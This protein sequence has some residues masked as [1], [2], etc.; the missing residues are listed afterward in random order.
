MRRVK[1]RIMYVG[2][3]KNS[4]LDLDSS[5]RGHLAHLK[6]FGYV[7]LTDIFS[8]AVLEQIRASY[9]I[10][11]EEKLNFETPCLAQNKID[12]GKHKILLDNYLR[13]TPQQ[14]LEQGIA[15]TK[16]EVSSY[17]QVLTE[18]R[19]STLKTYIPNN[20]VFYKI[21]LHP[22][23]LN[24]VEAYMGLRPYLVEAYLRRNF[25]ADH[26]VMN[27]FWHRDTNHKDYLVK[28]FIFLSDCE[29]HHGPHEYIAES[30]N[31]MRFK[32]RPY[33]TDEEIDRVYPFGHQSR[34]TSIVRAG[35]I[36]LEDTRGLH[37]AMVP[38]EGFRD[39]GYA[40][41]FPRNVFYRRSKPHFTLNLET[42]N[43]LDL[44]QRSFIAH[45]NIIK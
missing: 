28:A 9:K 24:I 3:H 33:Y 42:Y 13:Y 35:T 2:R 34:I 10:E 22:I 38:T 45:E 17:Q 23:I 6:R 27:H 18:F 40:V 15:F 26:K 30:I 29:L 1:E 37:R 32:G 7:M 31:D 4:E 20:N 41:F 36:I 25:P 39:L 16:N 14:Y 19:P 12:V 21:W 8:E 5:L 11:L 43:Q 44:R